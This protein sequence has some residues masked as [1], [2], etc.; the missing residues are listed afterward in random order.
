M[1]Y[2][3]LKDISHFVSPFDIAKSAGTWTPTVSSNLVSDVRTAAG[4]AF[5]ILIPIVLPGSLVGTQ[6][7]K[8]ISIDVFYKIGTAAATAFG[9]ALNKVSLN[10]HGVASAGAAVSVTLDAD[11]DTEAERYAVEDHK[12]TITLGSPVFLQKNAAYFVSCVITAAAGTVFTLFG[13]Q[14]NYELRV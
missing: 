13:A 7:A 12:M 5:T 2:T 14:I 6:G 3:H 11:H 9:V 4:A 8:I 10:A 1:G